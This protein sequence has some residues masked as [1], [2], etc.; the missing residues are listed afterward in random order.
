MRKRKRN[1]LTPPGPRTLWA[2]LWAAA[3]LCTSAAAFNLDSRVPLIKTPPSSDPEAYFG[4]SVSQHRTGRGARG[5]S[6]LLVGAPR[7]RNLQP[8]TERSGALFRCPMSNEIEVREGHN[9]AIVV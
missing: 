9:D 5:E 2:A 6:V 7:G 1:Q 8:G 4:F 3:L